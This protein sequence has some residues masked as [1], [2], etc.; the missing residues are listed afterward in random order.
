M[1]HVGLAQEELQGLPCSDTCQCVARIE[2]P[3]SG[4]HVYVSE[5]FRFA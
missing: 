2:E 1:L 3:E 5:G 4:C